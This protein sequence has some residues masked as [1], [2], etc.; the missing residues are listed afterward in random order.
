MGQIGR[1]IDDG[2]DREEQVEGG[3]DVAASL[4]VAGLGAASIAHVG[5]TI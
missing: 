1:P 3:H 5:R 4:E 2:S